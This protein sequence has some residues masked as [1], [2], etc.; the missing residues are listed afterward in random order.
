VNGVGAGRVWGPSYVA[1][2]PVARHDNTLGAPTGALAKSRIFFHEGG[3]V[4]RNFNQYLWY[5]C[6]W[7]EP[8]SSFI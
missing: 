8:P 7:K 5:A 4:G 6:P 3:L 1:S 2:G